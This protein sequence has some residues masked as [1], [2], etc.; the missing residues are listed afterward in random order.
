MFKIMMIWQLIPIS[1]RHP[2]IRAHLPNSLPVS[3][4]MLIVV[5]LLHSQLYC[6]SLFICAGMTHTHTHT[7]THRVSPAA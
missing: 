3:Q 6:I 5:T 4:Q 7:H 2:P 1:M